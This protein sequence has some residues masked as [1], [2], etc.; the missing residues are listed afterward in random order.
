MR[1]ARDVST[2]CGIRINR[3]PF[4]SPRARAREMICLSGLYVSDRGLRGHGFASDV[5]RIRECY[6]GADVRISPSKVLRVPFFKGISTSPWLYFA[7]STHHHRYLYIYIYIGEHR[8]I[9]IQT[10]P[11]T[12]PRAFCAR[13][14]CASLFTL[15]SGSFVLAHAGN[16]RNIIAQRA[17]A[18][19]R[20]LR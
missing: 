16:R 19:A 12:R 4:F 8:A 6:S 17:P 13:P 7:Y 5:I 3:V 2:R 10:I 20:I 15:I 11:R 14:D 9:C 18:L 1:R